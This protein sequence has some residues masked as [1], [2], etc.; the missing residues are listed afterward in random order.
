MSASDAP[1][2]RYRIQRTIRQGTTA[3]TTLLNMG[4]VA[5]FPN[6]PPLL[7]RYKEWTLEHWKK[8]LTLTVLHSRFLGRNVFLTVFDCK[9]HRDKAL[10]RHPPTIS[11]AKLLP[12]TP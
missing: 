7:D 12:W 10:G 11:T 4:L 5:I 9:I 1:P 6:N 8:R 2:S 3:M